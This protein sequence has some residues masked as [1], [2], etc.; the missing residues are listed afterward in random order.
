MPDKI[1]FFK[2]ENKRGSNGLVRVVLQFL[3]VKQHGNMA[4]GQM[5][6]GS[7]KD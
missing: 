5:S 3:E 1:G 4:T 2:I 7:V 6:T